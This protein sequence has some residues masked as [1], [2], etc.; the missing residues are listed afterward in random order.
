MRLSVPDQPLPVAFRLRAQLTTT[1]LRFEPPQ[2][3]FGDCVLSERTAVRAAGLGAQIQWQPR[4]D[5]S[6][7]QMV[8]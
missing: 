2:L 8:A 1:E 6:P 7:H 3:D 4:P 5:G